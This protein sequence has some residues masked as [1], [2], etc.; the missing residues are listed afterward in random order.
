MIC[1]GIIGPWQLII[2]AVPIVTFILG[3]FI[4]K[5]VGYIKRVKETDT[6]N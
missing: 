3:Y 5:K 2:L 1:L 6:K 4:G